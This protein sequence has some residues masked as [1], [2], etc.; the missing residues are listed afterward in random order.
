MSP[1]LRV[2][3]PLAATIS[4]LLAITS[5]AP[6]AA[7]SDHTDRLDIWRQVAASD[8]I[9][10]ASVAS[11]EVRD[12]FPET[13]V[14]TLANDRELHKVGN[15]EIAPGTRTVVGVNATEWR[16]LYGG[17]AP[18]DTERLIFFL[19][20]GN[21]AGASWSIL[22]NG[23]FKSAVVTPEA[24]E[25]EIQ[26]QHEAL[27][28][29]TVDETSKDYAA[30][31]EAIDSLTQ[32]GLICDA[33]LKPG[34]RRYEK[35]YQALIDRLIAEPPD[36]LPLVVD[37]MLWQMD[38]DLHCRKMRLVAN[39]ADA[40][41][42]LDRVYEPERVVDALSAALT[43]ATGQNFGLIAEGADRDT[44]ARTWALYVTR[45]FPQPKSAESAPIERLW[46]DV[47]RADWIVE[48]A[49]L[50]EPTNDS[51]SHYNLTFPARTGAVLKKGGDGPILEV[52]VMD[53]AAP[54]E[55]LRGAVGK[56]ALLF[57]RQMVTRVGDAAGEP[58]KG[59]VTVY[60]VDRV[61]QIDSEEARE[62]ADEVQRQAAML[63]AWRLTADTEMTTRV[64]NL[65]ASFVRA[66]TESSACD[67]GDKLPKENDYQFLYESLV[68][69]GQDAVPSIIALMDDV[70]PLPCPTMTE[71]AIA[72]T[73]LIWPW[74]PRYTNVHNVA[75]V[76]DLILTYITGDY[77]RGRIDDDYERQ[78]VIKA[79]KIYDAVQR[80]PTY[81]D[82][83]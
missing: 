35:S 12:G 24:V 54:A 48:V 31:A 10:E 78:Q 82:R 18:P 62:V 36:R 76:L 72:T 57:L 2:A 29:W 71:P 77:V 65:I 55:S 13:V 6:V 51:W 38:E 83:R 28:A 46:L 43:Q 45:L 8:L 60:A 19:D 81:E 20:S 74:Q 23:V 40:F 26:S 16:N 32:P 50:G 39:G 64:K 1:I 30:I 11:A 73:G 22:A 4:L 69:L 80:D 25:T 33:N 9:L 59:H 5:P 47:A 61:V 53:Q 21:A 34:D 15:W 49:L 44:V 63:E 52:R 42:N 75:M 37:R 41:G 79:W 56:T 58:V 27:A 70:R 66:E 3:L 67:T 17:T 7:E 68:K 14:L